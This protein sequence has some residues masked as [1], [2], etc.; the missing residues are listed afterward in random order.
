MINYIT[1]KYFQNPIEK[2]L[3]VIYFI[4]KTLHIAFNFTF[5][6][7]NNKKKFFY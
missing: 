3:K 2:C 5:S 4:K 7:R 6:Q 1:Q